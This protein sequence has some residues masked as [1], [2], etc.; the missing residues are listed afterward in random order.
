MPDLISCTPIIP[1]ADAAFKPRVYRLGDLLEDWNRD[2]EAAHQAHLTGMPRGPLT[3]FPRL[4]QALGDVLAPGLHILHGQPG[5]G[6]SAFVL[7]VAASCRCPALFLTVEMSPLE[8][9]RRLTARVTNTFLGDL[10][11][12][13]LS[14]KASLELARRAA[15]AAPDLL[16]VDG[17]SAF[18]SPE[19]LRELAGACLQ[20]KPHLLLVIDSAHAWSD[21]SPC[22]A[23]EYDALNACLTSLRMLTHELRCPALVVA[24]R[25]RA[26]MQRGGMSAS[27][28]S[29]KFEYI[30][31]TVIDLEKDPA[32]AMDAD[33]KVRVLVS[34]AKNRHGAAGQ[35]I[36]MTFRGAKQQFAE[37]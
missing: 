1:P 13:R 16:L 3:G 20:D 9:F 15:N 24:E 23:V 37:C 14:P 10:K 6:K 25:N 27:A 36:L 11:S 31:E 22:E 33:G 5:T 8:L 12:G 4:D 21:S 17:T 26:N 7:Q 32:A 18:V 2:A 28:G 30:A 34:V 35:E 19:L 29:R